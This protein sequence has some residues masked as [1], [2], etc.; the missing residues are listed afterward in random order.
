MKTV[1]CHFYNE[2][3]LLPW[4]LIHHKKYFDHGIMIN[5]QSTDNSV[6]IIKEICPTWDIIDSRNKYFDAPLVDREVQEIEKN[7]KGWKCC[8]TITEFLFG[9]FFSLTEE[10]SNIQYLVPV[11]LMTD[12]KIQRDSA[13]IDKNIPLYD[14]ITTGVKIEKSIEIFNFRSLHNYNVFYRR[15][16]RHFTSTQTDHKFIILKYQYAPMTKEFINR[17]LQIQYRLPPNDVHGLFHS[18]CGKGF[19]EEKITILCKGLSKRYSVD[20]KELLDDLKNR[21]NIKGTN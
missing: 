2:E 11:I 17:K 14:Q 15:V 20:Y 19:T 7:I 8:L 13:D 21:S 12:P 10:Q 16:G 9:D 6:K 5:Y 3:Y 4:W 1:I 18:D